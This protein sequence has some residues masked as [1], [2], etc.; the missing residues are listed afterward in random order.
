MYNNNNYIEEEII[1]CAQIQHGYLFYS[2]IQIIN[3]DKLTDFQILKIH[4]MG[5]GGDA[6][7][8]ISSYVIRKKTKSGLQLYSN[9]SDV[10]YWHSTTETLPALF[11]ITVR[12]KY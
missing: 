7:F 4:P 12:Y 9:N 3:A 10:T 2:E 8:D 1:V 5:G 11:G 6:T